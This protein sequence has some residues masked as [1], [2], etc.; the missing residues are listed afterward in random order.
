[1]ISRKTKITK[2]GNKMLDIAGM[3]SSIKKI[4]TKNGQPML[5][6]GIEDLTSKIEGLVFPSILEKNPDIFIEGA[7]IKIKGRLSDKDGTLKILCEE[8]KEL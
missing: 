3:I 5:F 7:T 1:M 6:I 2:H 4:T 8:V